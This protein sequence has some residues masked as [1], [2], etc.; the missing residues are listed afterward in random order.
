MWIDSLSIMLNL[1]KGA[2]L[3]MLDQFNTVG[4]VSGTLA[5]GMLIS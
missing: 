5:G 1:R 4:S 2:W 3:C